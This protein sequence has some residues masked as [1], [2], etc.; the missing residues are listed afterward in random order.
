MTPKQAKVLVALKDYW[1]EN[2]YAPTYSEMAKVLKYKTPNVVS[3]MVF[4][5]AK[6]GI[7]DCLTEHRQV[8]RDHTKGK[9]VWKKLIIHY[10]L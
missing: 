3:N 8:Y 9:R 7:C 6:K 5:L 4:Q 2:Q 10:R 1:N